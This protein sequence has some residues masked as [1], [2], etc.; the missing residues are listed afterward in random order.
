MKKRVIL[1]LIIIFNISFITSSEP[2]I[3]LP[4][5]IINYTSFYDETIIQGDNLTFNIFATDNEDLVNDTLTY[6]WYL[7]NLVKS[8]ENVF[9]I[10][11]ISSGFQE[12]KVE[13]SDGNL[14]INHKWQI[15]VATKTKYEINK[16][17]PYFLIPPWM[18]I[19]II[20]L[21]ILIILFYY[22]L[23][24]MKKV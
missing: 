3:N 18:G 1:I 8:Y 9:E 14:S 24:E 22:I 13:I 11:N 10:K 21:L 2:I 15:N 5:K 6:K 17:E 20:I 16:K 4:P 12:I 19:A 23:K 7:N